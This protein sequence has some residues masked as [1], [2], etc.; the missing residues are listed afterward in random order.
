[1]TV[2]A[3]TCNGQGRAYRF[4]SS[5]EADDHPLVQLGDPIIRSCAE[6]LRVYSEEDVTELLERHKAGTRPADLWYFLENSAP[7]APSD[8]KLICDLVTEDRKITR[9]SGILLAKS[10][11]NSYGLLRKNALTAEGDVIMATEKGGAAA[12]KTKGGGKKSGETK[13]P[14]AGTTA[15][16]ATKD[17][18]GMGQSIIKFKVDKDGKLYGADN[19]PKRATAKN[20]GR[21]LLYKDGMTIDQFVEAGG[22]RAD[23]PHDVK[24]G[25]IELLPPPALKEAAATT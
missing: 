25:Y 21:F 7:Q 22:H 12:P 15:A 5:A 9:K 24:K 4:G 6:M 17:K 19:N 14:A 8:P 20:H 10:A 18:V 3:V 2:I 13:A 1:M 16:A 11:Q 23:V